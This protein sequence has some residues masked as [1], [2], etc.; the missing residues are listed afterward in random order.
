HVDF[1]LS[2]A[3]G[4]SYVLDSEASTCDDEGTNTDGNGQCTIVFT[5]PSA[6]T[7]TGNASATLVALGLELTRSTSGNSGPGGSGPA[8]KQFV[9]ANIAIAPDATNEVD[10]P[11][12]FTVTVNED[13]GAGDGFVPA[14]GEHVDYTLTDD[15]G[16]AS[17]LDAEA[18]TCDDD[19]AN[20]DAN[21]QCTI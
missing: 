16:A 3:G 21:G 10:A 8:V 19:G 20:T 2:D 1:T 11:H 4:A 12:T 7:V 14:V 18:S 17:A 6:G 13:A 5:S 9:D 15:A